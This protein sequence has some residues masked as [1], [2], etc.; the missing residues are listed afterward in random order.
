MIPDNDNSLATDLLV[1][2]TAIAEFTGMKPRTLYH[3]A[4]KRAIPTF[5]MGDLVCARKS[6]LI[7]F[8][9]AQE[10]AA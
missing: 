8:I 6:K 10:S 5:K 3:L 1:G 2:V 7:A 4:S 9:E